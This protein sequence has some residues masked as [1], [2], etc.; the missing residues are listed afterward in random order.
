MFIFFTW[1]IEINSSFFL[2]F[3]SK[4]KFQLCYY[5]M[6]VIHFPAI[7]LINNRGHD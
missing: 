6:K 5:L 1:K 2:L 3:L 4:L 7:I